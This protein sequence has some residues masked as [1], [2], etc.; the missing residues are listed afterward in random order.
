MIIKERLAKAL[1]VRIFFVI[2][3]NRTNQKS[4]LFEHSIQNQRLPFFTWRYRTWISAMSVVGQRHLALRNDFIHV[5]G[6][7]CLWIARHRS[8]SRHTSIMGRGLTF[9]AQPS[10]SLLS[11]LSLCLSLSLLVS[12]YLSLSF[13]VSLC[14]SLALMEERPFTG[15]RIAL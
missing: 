14:L 12:L 1:P 3:M 5:T 10:Q 15:M 2:S 8:I 13:L 7:I 9:L 11:C 4:F 6:F